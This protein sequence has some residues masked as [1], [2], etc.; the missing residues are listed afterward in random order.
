MDQILACLDSSAH[1]E[2]VVRSAAWAAQRLGCG[3]ELLHVLQRDDSVAERN[4]HSGAVGLGARSQLLEELASLDEQHARLERERGNAV[5]KFA[6]AHLA[7]AGIGD[8]QVT[9]RHG[10]IVETVIERETDASL[11][12]VG[13]RGE[14]SDSAAGH[15]GA[16][17]EHILR[18]SVRPVLVT[19]TEVPEHSR[20]FV[21]FD[22][23]A[24]G[25]RI[26][27]LVRTSPLFAGLDLHIAIAGHRRD[28]EKGALDKVRS[29]LPHAE[30][31]HL[32][33]APDDVLPKAWT[34]RGADLVVMGA[35]G[36]SPLR[37]WI[38]G[39]VTTQMLRAARVPVLVYR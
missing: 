23:S 4:D 39:S 3:I 14:S 18:E 9:H 2:G 21:C 1:A 36:H 28:V 31:V 7:E 25:W 15:I 27:E 37:R 13:K 32:E 35:Y 17:I 19:R 10:G 34:D 8:V 30:V 33:G 38:V 22:A 29:A 16:L 26:I 5:L 12:V 6:Q 11:V 20:A 24:T